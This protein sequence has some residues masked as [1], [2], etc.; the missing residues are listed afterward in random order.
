VERLSGR[1]P[2]QTGRSVRSSRT[3]RSRPP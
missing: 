2:R 3:R 1:A